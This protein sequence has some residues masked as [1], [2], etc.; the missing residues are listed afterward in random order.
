MLASA[1]I[2]RM[3]EDRTAKE[4]TAK[5]GFSLICCFLGRGTVKK[6][7]QLKKVGSELGLF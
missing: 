2:V 3:R 7:L 5:L 4:R 6:G 1:L